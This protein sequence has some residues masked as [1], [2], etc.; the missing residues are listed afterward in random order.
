MAILNNVYLSCSALK[1]FNSSVQSDCAGTWV[2]EF[3]G[4]QLHLAAATDGTISQSSL[5]NPDDCVLLAWVA[6]EW[7]TTLEAASRSALHLSS[8][9]FLKF[10]FRLNVRFLTEQ[11]ES[12]IPAK[13]F[14]FFSFSQSIFQS[15]TEIR[16]KGWWYQH[17]S[18][19][20]GLKVDCIMTATVCP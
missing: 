12:L 9:H 4:R 14:F 20:T 15:D 5:N 18:C 7:K 11:L 1:K 13:T 6:H 17:G 19:Q 2:W 16:F 3:R 8:F 10:I